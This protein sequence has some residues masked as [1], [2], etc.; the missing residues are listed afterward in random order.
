MKVYQVY[1]EGFEAV[2]VSRP[3]E[4][5]E[6]SKKLVSMLATNPAEFNRYSIVEVTIK[7]GEYYRSGNTLYLKDEAFKGIVKG[8][9][10]SDNPER[11]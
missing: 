2:P 6:D 8:V 4:H 3:F 7:P 10:Y 1:Y 5:F 9:Y 11:I